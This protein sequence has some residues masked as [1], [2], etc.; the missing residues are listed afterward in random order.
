MDRGGPVVCLDTDPVNATLSTHK[1]LCAEHVEMT[2]EASNTINTR[3]FDQVVERFLKE[4]SDFV[5]D[6]GASSFL[7]LSNYLIENPVFDM[8]AESGKATFLHTVITGDKPSTRRCSASGIWLTRCPRRS[9]LLS[10]STNILV[11]LKTRKASLS[12][13]QSLSVQQASRNRSGAASAHDSGHVRHRCEG[14]G[15]T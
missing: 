8:V 5:L 14:Y 6:N 9:A 7:P 2:D 15:R 10:G 12:R 11:V 1:A 3:A 13:R 4:D